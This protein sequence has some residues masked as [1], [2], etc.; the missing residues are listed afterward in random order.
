LFFVMVDFDVIDL[1]NECR[2]LLPAVYK[3]L[4][5]VHFPVADELDD[6]EDIEEQLNTN[7]GKFPEG[8]VAVVR[9]KGEH[10]GAL[11]GCAVFEY[12]PQSNSALLS[13]IC[14]AARFRRRGLSK[15]LL[16]TTQEAVAQRAGGPVRALYAETHRCDVDDGIM[17]P[18][19]RQQVLQGLGF[20]CLPITYV[21]PPLSAHHKPCGGM[22]L[23]AWGTA[24]IPSAAVLEFLHDFAGSMMDYDGSWKSEEYFQVMARE[25]AEQ[26]VVHGRAELYW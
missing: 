6:L 22:W 21:Q 11:M 15:V 20:R 4:L 17:D 18:K 7:D 19:E 14:V 2:D 24:P 5:Q 1:R 9:G 16:K 12:Y 3:D 23:L 8:H 25:L 10:Q 26:E 13:Y